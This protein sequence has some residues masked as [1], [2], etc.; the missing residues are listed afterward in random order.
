MCAPQP[1]SAR[2]HQQVDDVAGDADGAELRELDPVCPPPERGTRARGDGHCREASGRRRAQCLACGRVGQGAEPVMSGTNRTGA[3]GSRLHPPSSSVT[4]MSCRPS[5]RT[6]RPPGASW[7]S[8]AC[9]SSAAAAATAIASNGACGGTPSEPSPTQH[10]HRAVAGRRE[11]AA[12][13]VGEL[14]D[15]LHRD[16]PA[17]ELVED[18]GL[19]AGAGADVEDELV[20]SRARAPGRSARRRTAARSSGRGRAR[21]QRRRRRACSPRQA[22]TTRAAPSASRRGRA[23]R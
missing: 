13:H 2:E 19:V 6:S 3:R 5:G 9:G 21:A 22:R 18:R 20:A 16:D 11:V 1:S 7:S 12:G 15:P 10:L 17:G 23:G 4:R 14:G 8:S